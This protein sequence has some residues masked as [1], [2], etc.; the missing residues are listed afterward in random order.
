MHAGLDSR[1]GLRS[2]GRQEVR[3]K[4]V[5]EGVF[6]EGRR[7]RGFTRREFLGRLTTAGTTALAMAT[8]GIF[9]RVGFRAPPAS[10][11]DADVATA[12]FTLALTLVRDTPGFSPPVA[13]RAFAYSGLTLYE[14]LVPGMPG[15]RTLA[16]QLKELNPAPEPPEEVHHWP[17]VANA[18]LASIV[19]RLFPTS[20]AERQA[21]VDALERRLAREYRG[22][23]P[24][25]VFRR[26]V[27][28]GRS[29]AR[30]VFDWSR[31]DGGHAAYLD[32]FPA[33]SPP[34]GPGLWVPTPP[35]FLPALQPYWGANRRFTLAS[36]AD[37]NPGPPPSYSEASLSPF[38]A[39]A[40]A[41]YEV[42]T[43]LTSEQEEIALFWSDDPAAT[44]TPPGHWVSILTQAIDREDFSLDVAAEAYAK[45]GMAVADAFIA[46][47]Q[48]KYRYDLLRPVTYIQR[49]VDP[50]WFPLLVT[51]PFP[52]Y[53]SGH[54]VQSAAA[55]EVLTKMFGTVSFIDHT[56]DD[57]GL[58]P[59]SFG[60]FFEAAEEAALSRL[61]GGIHFA[62]AI[63]RG[64]EQGRCVGR[65]VSRLRFR[66]P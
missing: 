27:S 2:F 33:Y 7:A 39:E 28:R 32:D 57:R 15:Y 8:P 64:L 63:E 30:Q 4:E 60:S 34:V 18:A 43:N 24:P 66:V 35:R 61:Y 23:V 46:C 44:F 13:S 6:S 25:G 16:G 5:D 41:C 53:T 50:V 58:T 37:R 1:L 62:S 48:T 14:A 65:R 59:R 36:G 3:V 19:R 10:A 29:I 45:V 47:W 12:W 51:P 42:T 21:D 9:Q 56:H 54:S 11:F 52:E 26:S 55:A 17:T 49:V 20:P 31:T 22:A 38:D 40:R